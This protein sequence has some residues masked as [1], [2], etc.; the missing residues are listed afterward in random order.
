MT[1]LPALLAALVAILTIATLCYAFLCW[2]RPFKPCRHCHGTT[3]Q[4]GRITGRAR[5]CRHCDHTGL[6]LRAGRHLANHLRRLH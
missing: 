4:T 5:P 2:V 6:Q 3:R 1:P